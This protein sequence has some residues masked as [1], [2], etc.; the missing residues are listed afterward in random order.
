MAEIHN[1]DELLTLSET[2]KRSCIEC[3]EYQPQNITRKSEMHV[4]IV[5]FMVTNIVEIMVINHVPDIRSLDASSM[6]LMS[7]AQGK[8]A[9]PYVLVIAKTFNVHVSIIYRLQQ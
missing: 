3:R 7:A 4:N 8:Q 5:E 1:T 9:G 6:S 2:S